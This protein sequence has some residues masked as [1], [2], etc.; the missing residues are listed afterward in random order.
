MSRKSNKLN[1]DIIDR[2][3]DSSIIEDNP[4][5]KRVKEIKDNTKANANDELLKDS[6]L[7]NVLNI[8]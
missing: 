3:K 8:G 1:N 7:I 5:S 4:F 2:E 6:E